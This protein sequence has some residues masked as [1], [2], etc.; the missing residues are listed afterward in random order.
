META[1]WELILALSY[2]NFLTS[3]ILSKNTAL[4]HIYFFDLMILLSVLIPFT[5]SKW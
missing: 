2:E 1:M 3:N 4:S 5:S